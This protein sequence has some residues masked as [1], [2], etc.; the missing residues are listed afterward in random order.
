MAYYLIVLLGG[1]SIFIFGLK[2][3][4]EGTESF[5]T[6]ADTRMLSRGVKNPFCG[7]TV[8]ALVAGVTQ[9]SVAVSFITVGLVEAKVIP[10]LYSVPIIMGANIG[11]TIT[12]Q[13]ISLSGKSGLII[14]SISSII[15]LLLGF[16]KKDT[17]KSLGNIAISLGLLFAGLSMMDSGLTGLVKY[18]WFTWLFTVPNPFLLF[19]N[20]LVLTSFLQS[21]SV[22][23]GITVIL[24][25]KG[26]LSFSSAVF[27]TLGSNVGSC[28]SVIVASLNKTIEARRAS[29]FNLCFNFFGSVIF[30]PLAVAFSDSLEALFFMKNNDVGRAI[31][32]FHTFFNLACVLIFLP[33]TRILTN[34]ICKFVVD[35]SKISQIKP[36]SKTFSNKIRRF[37]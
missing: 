8:G 14:G 4:S 24:A 28:F 18:G 25:S 15:G 19:L 21:S 32:N 9:S 37:N 13:L 6:S 17:L 33:F 5:I 29:I 26:V 27:I 16:C 12:A 3:I 10:F 7:V 35:K 34:L 1:I 31:A 23:T 20:G 11:T 36:N 2:G 22:V 30:F